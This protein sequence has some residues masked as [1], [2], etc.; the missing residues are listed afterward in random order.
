MSGV[1]GAL[2]DSDGAA[3]DAVDAQHL[4][5]SARA[6]HVDD[7]IDRTD[8]VELDLV[9]VGAVHRTLHLGEQREHAMRT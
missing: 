5:R 8:L 9:G 4:E 6:H 7:R 1:H 2:A 3:H